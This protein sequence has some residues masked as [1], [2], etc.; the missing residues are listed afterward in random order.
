M[1]RLLIVTLILLVAAAYIT[2]TYFKNLNPPGKNTSQVIRN[3]PGNAALVFEYTNDNGFYEIFHGNKL[4]ATIAGK[5]N[6]DQL[7][8]LRT[9]LIINTT[10]STFF[11]DQNLFIS[12]HPLTEKGTALLFTI[13]LKKD[14]DIALFNTLAKKQSKDILITPFKAAGKNGYTIYLKALGKRFFIVN[15]GNNILSG[16]FS[17]ELAA[18]S[19]A[20]TGD[21]EQ[22]FTLLPAQQN[23]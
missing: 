8:L 11:N 22:P 6:L 4:F 16:S 10:L 14:F 3:I 13:A 15:K 18:Q 23:T 19:A 7:N 21:N 2:V 12:V 9:S 1:K 17:K 5:E 20:Y